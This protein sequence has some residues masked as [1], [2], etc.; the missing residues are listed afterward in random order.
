MVS[1]DMDTK[2]L[3]Q[4][5]NQPYDPETATDAAGEANLGLPQRIWVNNG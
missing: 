4:A 1:T 2:Q 3:K 5:A